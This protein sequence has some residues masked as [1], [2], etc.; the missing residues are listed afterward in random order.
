MENISCPSARRAHIKVSRM[1]MNRRGSVTVEA[2]V[3]LPIFICC[4][5]TVAFLI[6]VVYVQEKIQLAI[7]NAA[8]EMAMYSYLYEKSQ[9]LDVVDTLRGKTRG[10]A[11]AALQNSEEIYNSI[12]GIKTSAENIVREVES[13]K[14]SIDKVSEGG[15]FDIR[16]DIGKGNIAEKLLSVVNDLSEKRKRLESGIQTIYSSAESALDGLK[17][18]L[19]NPKSIAGLAAY[20][21]LGAMETAIGNACVKMLM[22]KNLTNEDLARYWVVDG[23]DGLDF[24]RSRYFVTDGD[25]GA[26]HV[27]D[28]IVLYKID[29]P[30]PVRII[31]EIPM[32]QRVTVRA[33]TGK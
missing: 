12:E 10:S 28:V 33:W 8:N 5:V 2:A 26:D 17:G 19:D 14:N 11:S 30:V 18:L 13:I 32:L 9:V 27:I 25:I 29:L 16:F 4:I 1:V 20:E 7:T 15:E 24:S 22:Q 3:A 6:R 21:G 31:D 23:Y